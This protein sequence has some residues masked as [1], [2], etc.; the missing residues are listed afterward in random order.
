MQHTHQIVLF[1]VDGLRP[2]ALPLVS[3]PQIDALAARG[4]YTWSAQTVMPSI[5]LTGHV[6]LMYG[7]PT[8]RHQVVSSLWQPAD[9]PIPSLIDV[10]HEAGLGTAAFYTWEELRDLS[11]PGALDTVYFRREDGEA[12]NMIDIARV[13]AAYIAEQRPAL[14]FVYL[15]APDTLGHSDGWMSTRYLHAVE[16][17]DRAVGLVIDALRVAGWLENVTILLTA[18]HG[19]HEDRHGTDMPEDMTIPWIIAG[20]GIRKGHRIASPVN[21]MDTAP[22]LA[23]ILG[24]PV[25]EAWEGR[26]VDQVFWDACSR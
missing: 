16:K 5:T 10:V 18:D 13:A 8:A 6:S 20:P 2:D 26:V 17:V 7:V 3:T 12:D 9:P 21:I 19:G 14:A 11:R 23:T 4:A 25:P 24:L 15:E 1:S 22:T